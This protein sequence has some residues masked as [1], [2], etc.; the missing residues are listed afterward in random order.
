M[1]HPVNHNRPDSFSLGLRLIGE[2]LID[3]LRGLGARSVDTPWSRA[4]AERMADCSHC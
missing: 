4:R 2:A 1:M 3:G